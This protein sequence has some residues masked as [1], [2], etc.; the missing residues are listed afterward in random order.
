VQAQLEQLKAAPPP[1]ALPPV[2]P[3]QVPLPR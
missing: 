2:Q 1:E 3:A